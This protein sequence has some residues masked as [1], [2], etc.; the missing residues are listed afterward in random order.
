M[1]NEQKKSA[2]STVHLALMTNNI[3][4]FGRKIFLT[5]CVLYCLLIIVIFVLFIPKINLLI[6]EHQNIK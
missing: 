6:A 2:V 4:T 5:Q 1:S 3:M